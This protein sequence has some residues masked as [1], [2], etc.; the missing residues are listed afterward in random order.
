MV[1]RILTLLVAA[2]VPFAAHAQELDADSFNIS[3]SSF[4]DEGMLQ[5]VHPHIGNP[6][7]FYAGLGVVYSHQPLVYRFSDG[8]KEVLVDGQL[9]TRIAGG[10][11]LLGAVRLDVEVPIFPY[12]SVA[13]T[14]NFALGDIRVGAV[15][16]ILKYEEEGIGLGIA[17]YASIPTAS[18]GAWLTNGGFSGGAVATLGGKAGILNWA[19]N[20][21]ADLG[22]AST[23]SETTIGS[24]IL[25]G[26]GFSVDISD[27]F[28]AGVEVNSAWDLASGYAWNES[29]VEAHAF[30]TYGTGSGLTATLGVGTGLV[31]G[32]GAPAFRGLLLLGYRGAGK[33]IV[34]DM[35]GDGLEDDVDQCPEKPEDKD[36]YADTDG[37]PDTDNDKDG[38]L[39]TDD[40]CPDEA[41]DFDKFSDADGCPD[42]DNDL[43]GIL[44]DADKCPDVKGIQA[45]QGCPDRDADGI[46]D[47]DDAC[48]DEAG[49]ENTNGCPDK[50][51][52]RVP[53]SRDK[54]PDV[55][56]DSRI[57]PKRSDGCPARVIVTKNAIQ[58]LDKVYFDT[59]KTTI[60]KISFTLLDEV[61]KVIVDNPDIKL[62]EVSGHTDSV[63]NDAANLKLSQGRAEAVVKYL[64][65]TGKVE[66]ARLIAKG[67]GETKPIDTNDTDAGKAMNRR[68]EFNILEQ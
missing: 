41:E 16:P 65:T 23:V 20:A 8:T 58:I 13:T 34:H 11:N 51:G 1:P 43:D 59:N 64:A 21:G 67:Y 12:N 26:G 54:C 33:P 66:A 10:F 15:V 40:K 68:V 37:C 24:Q 62:I 2:G 6:S 31:P 42:P 39:D 27:A 44:D 63:G 18:S 53:D 30:G 60:K 32:V 46:T 57:D 25:A 29:P 49:P 35:D 14:S 45:L 52:D 48:P 19:V 50:D 61:A 56:A 47:A 38:L 28:L 5:M 3:G 36:G 55:P 7:S 22:G 17:P 4:D 9:S